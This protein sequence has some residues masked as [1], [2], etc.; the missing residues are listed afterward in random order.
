MY[1]LY[2]SDFKADI[3]ISLNCKIFVTH[4]SARFVRE[5]ETA[6]KDE[7]IACILVRVYK[8][9][10]SNLYCLVMES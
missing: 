1:I 6:F 5:P 9:R 2:S 7:M 8:F 4:C 3:F 10:P